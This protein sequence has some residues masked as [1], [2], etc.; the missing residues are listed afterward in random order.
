MKVVTT[1]LLNR[2]WKNGVIPIKYA[3][4]SKFDTSKIV[5]SANITEEGFVMDGK[6]ASE[7]F[8][9]LNGK[10]TDTDIAL[11]INNSYLTAT[12]RRVGPTVQYSINV[13]KNLPLSTSI[14]LYTLPEEYRPIL[15]FYTQFGNP[16]SVPNIRLG[17]NE[18]GRITAYLYN[19]NGYGNAMASGS[20]VR[21]NLY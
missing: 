15:T 4:S 8:A 3:I 21:K 10:I 5:K 11:S 14:T 16:G 18:E 7:K 2:F 20:Y 17:I 13:L 19:N 6:T 1:N 9:E 12:F